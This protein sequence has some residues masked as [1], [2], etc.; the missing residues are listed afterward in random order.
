M[1]VKVP[2]VNGR[3][4]GRHDAKNSVKYVLDYVSEPETMKFCCEC[5]GRLGGDDT[6]P[7]PPR[8]TP[9]FCTHG[10]TCGRTGCGGPRRWASPLRGDPGTREFAVKWFKT[11]QR[12]PCWTRGS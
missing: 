4:P 6:A 3:H 5:I 11:A 12:L 9:S 1:V 7:P 8:P 2:D 10:P